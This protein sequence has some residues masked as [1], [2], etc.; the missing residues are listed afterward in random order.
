VPIYT[1]APEEIK[2]VRLAC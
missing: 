1:A 2:L